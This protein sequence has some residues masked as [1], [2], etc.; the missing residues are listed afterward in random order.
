MLARRFI[1]YLVVYCLK[2]LVTDARVKVNTIQHM[3]CYDVLV[4]PRFLWS[5]YVT[6]QNIIF[7]PCGF[8]L[9]SFFLSFFPRLISAVGDWMSNVYHTSTH[10]VALVRI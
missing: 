5:P 2:I 8:Y 3:I 4:V 7:L 1:S 6:G 10:G 9:S